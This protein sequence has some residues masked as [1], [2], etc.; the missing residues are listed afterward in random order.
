MGCDVSKS[1]DVMEPQQSECTSA[2][3]TDTQIDTIRSTWPLLS[4]DMTDIGGKVFLRTFYEEPRTK[5]VFPQFSDLEDF[6]IAKHPFF[7]GHVAKFM[8][9][10]D[11]VVDNLDGPKASIQQL[12]LM[13]GARHATFQGFHLEYFDVFTKVLID[14]WETEIGEEFIPEVKECWVFV[15]AYIV[16]YLRQGYF[17]YVNECTDDVI[18][19][20]S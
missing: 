13:L 3:F 17:L 4:A 12:L 9:V 19:E 20:K 6:E 14:V 16:K 1:V 8:Q 18:E 5:D 7:K 10:V 11:A 2:E 15:F